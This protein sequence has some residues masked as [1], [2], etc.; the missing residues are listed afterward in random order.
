MKITGLDDLSQII[1]EW[2]QA[3]KQMEREYG[4]YL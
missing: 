4:E 2:Q 3:D 1:I